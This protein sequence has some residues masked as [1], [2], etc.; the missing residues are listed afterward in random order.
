MGDDV[1]I[2]YGAV[3]LTGVTIGRGA[4][5]AAGAIVRTN[6]DSYA[7]AAGNPAVQIAVRFEPEIAERHEKAVREAGYQF[8]EWSGITRKLGKDREP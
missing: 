1:W 2:G 6:I 7:I 4:V 3:I 8:S 5:I